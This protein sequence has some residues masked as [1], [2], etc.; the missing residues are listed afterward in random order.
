[1][2][3]YFHWGNSR[4]ICCQKEQSIQNHVNLGWN[5]SCMAICRPVILSTSVHMYTMESPIHSSVIKNTGKIVNQHLLKV[6]RHN[7]EY[8]TCTISLN[9]DKNLFNSIFVLFFLFQLRSWNL[10]MLSLLPKATELLLGRAEIQILSSF[11]GTFILNYD[12]IVSVLSLYKWR[13][14]T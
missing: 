9:H 4:K 11:S 13:E 14:K 8:L 5:L 3:P 2:F 7:A 6:L 12:V 1:M 10:E